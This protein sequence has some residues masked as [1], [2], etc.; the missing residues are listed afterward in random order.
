[1]AANTKM[2]GFW[3]TR[4]FGYWYSVV[5][6]DIWSVSFAAFTTRA[7][8]RA[9][10]QMDYSCYAAWGQYSDSCKII[11]TIKPVN[12]GGICDFFTSSPSRGAPTSTTTLIFFTNFTAE[13]WGNRNFVVR[14]T[15]FFLFSF[16]RLLRLP[17]YIHFCGRTVNLFWLAFFDC[18]ASIF[19]F[20]NFLARFS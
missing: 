19:L 8:L 14:Q 7:V 2:L 11:L 16:L 1:M 9:L 18:G 17:F 13:I 10:R 20:P 15:V 5:G 12:L 3:L 6:D 4:S